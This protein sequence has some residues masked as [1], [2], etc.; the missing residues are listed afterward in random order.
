MDHV[1]PLVAGAAFATLLAPGMLKALGRRA[2]WRGEELP[3][4]AGA[5]AV[6]AGVLALGALAVLDE[7]AGTHTLRAEP[8]IAVYGFEQEDGWTAY[9]PLPE[10]ERPYALLAGDLMGLA[11]LFLGI[12]LLGFLDDVVDAPPRG[13]RG[14]AAA[15]LR[16]SASTGI[17][18]AA[19]TAALAAV[20]LGGRGAPVGEYLLAIAVI[21]LASH[22]F[23]LLDL[24]PGRSWKAF[25]ALAAGLLIATQDTEPLRAVGPF[26][27]A[28]LVLG[29]YDLRE[30]AMLGDTGSN[31]LG[32][33]AG[34][35]LVMALESTG[36]AVAAG[37]LLALTIFGEFASISR[38][39]ERVPP[40]RSLD[41]LG[42][43]SHA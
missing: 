38:V 19:G 18:K 31:L 17:L 28:L 2:N 22:L 34:A 6:V 11:G 32:A 3:F 20:I 12:A 37:V 43:K 21:V 42:R 33:L 39:V 26:A 10:P 1:W 23:N 13:L 35:W 30:R 14:H 16:G 29:L 9:G 7:L 36:Q 25:V 41:S 5:V 27:G 8:L 40:L 15:L 24:R 4:P